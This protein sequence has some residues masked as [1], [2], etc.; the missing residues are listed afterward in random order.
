LTIWAA[1]LF[2]VVRSWSLRRIEER[3]QG[4]MGRDNRPADLEEL[5]RES[6]ERLNQIV[7]G[8]GSGKVADWAVVS[9]SLSR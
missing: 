2:A 3:T 9:G 5:I 7:R 6:Q 1:N 4:R 8:S